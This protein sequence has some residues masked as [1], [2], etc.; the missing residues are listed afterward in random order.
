MLT[1]RDVKGASYV[2]QS[3]GKWRLEIVAIQ[4]GVWMAGAIEMTVL[5]SEGPKELCNVLSGFCP[6]G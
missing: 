2:V 6:Q 1:R 5:D 4:V 3:V